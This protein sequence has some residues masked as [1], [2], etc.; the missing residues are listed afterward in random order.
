MQVTTWLVRN[1][2]GGVIGGVEM[3][4]DVSSMLV[5]L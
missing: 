5:D 4:R 1:T 2:A 3:I